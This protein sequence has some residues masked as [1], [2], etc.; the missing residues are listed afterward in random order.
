MAKL[1]PLTCLAASIFFP[2]APGIPAEGDPAAGRPDLVVTARPPA[3]GAH[4]E[5]ELDVHVDSLQ[6][7]GFLLLQVRS[8]PGEL[9][10]LGWR[11]GSALSSQ[12]E[13]N[14]E[15]PACDIV[16]YPDRST[17]QS[18][19]LFRG[20]YSTED[21]GTSYHLIRYRVKTDEARDVTLRFVAI[22]ILRESGQKEVFE[23]TATLSVEP[24]QKFLR[25]DA[26]NDARVDVADPVRL[27][28]RLYAGNDDAG[29]CLDGADANDDGWL[30]MDDA[31][32]V[33]Q[34]LFGGGLVSL[35]AQCALDTGTDSLP[36]CEGPTC[37]TSV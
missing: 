31:V 19:M 6:P 10:I 37:S 30:R 34:V 23:S 7:F 4:G 29:F 15:P 13:D 16:I 14:G 17:L 8:D 21:Y 27:L 2:C 18:V 11:P 22:R 5:F 24:G 1:A 28:Q 9:E 3:G 32:L 35:P 25:G 26:N 33:L 36:S 12:I 20:A